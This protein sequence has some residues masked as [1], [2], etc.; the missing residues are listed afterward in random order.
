MAHDQKRVE[1]IGSIRAGTPLTLTTE[2]EDS[3]EE[4]YQAHPEVPKYG[5]EVCSRLPTPLNSDNEDDG[6]EMTEDQKR[7][8]ASAKRRYSYRFRV[9][10]YA[11][12]MGPPFS[13][14]NRLLSL[15]GG[16][17]VAILTAGS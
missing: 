12:G 5:K 2:G 17:S 8:L 14:L 16:F 15:R 6:E 4:W 1:F 7:H 11:C 3:L 10:G 13:Y 9:N